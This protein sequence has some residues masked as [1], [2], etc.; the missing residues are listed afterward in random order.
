MSIPLKDAP[1]LRT[2][3]YI[4]RCWVDADSGA[5]LAVENPARGEIIAEVA[6]CGAAETRRAIEAARVAQVEWRQTTSKERAALLRS[7]FSR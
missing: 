7:W 2:Q 1:L 3:A 5:T 6:Q 4:N